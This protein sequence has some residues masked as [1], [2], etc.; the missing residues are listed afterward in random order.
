MKLAR[1]IRFGVAAPTLAAFLSCFAAHA[2][3]GQTPAAPAGGQ[4]TVSTS[5]ANAQPATSTAPGPSTASTP[6]PGT[7]P[8]T[9][10][11]GIHTVTVRFDYDFGVTPACTAKITKH[12]IQ[13]FI[14]YDISADAASPT[15]LFPIPVPTNPAGPIKNITKAGPPLDFQSGKHLIAV[16]AMSPDGTHSKRNL[17]TTWITI[18]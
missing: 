14:A 13:Q 6:I 12:C 5:P 10:S 9:T 1:I 15:M 8:P 16:S 18:P 2:A 7:P 17:C 3:S 11:H 4:A